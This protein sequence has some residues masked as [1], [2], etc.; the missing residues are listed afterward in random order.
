MAVGIDGSSILYL[1]GETNCNDFNK[2]E[3]G[4]ENTIGIK[5]QVISIRHHIFSL[6]MRRQLLLVDGHL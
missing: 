4:F 5:K 6:I 2:N 1:N 3:F